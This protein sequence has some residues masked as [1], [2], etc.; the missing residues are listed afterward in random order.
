MAET[1]RSASGGR[2]E[3]GNFKPPSA[4]GGSTEEGGSGNRLSRL[5]QQAGQPAIWQRAERLIAESTSKGPPA[6]SSALPLHARSEPNTATNLSFVYSY[7]RYGEA[8]SDGSYRPVACA[9]PAPFFSIREILMRASESS[10]AADMC[11][12][13]PNL[14]QGP[15]GPW[16]QCQPDRAWASWAGQASPPRLQRVGGCARFSRYARACCV[17]HA[18]FFYHFFVIITN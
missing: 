3:P 8:V 9:R 14:P 11:R 13:R 15:A 10:T 5:G 6:A 4:A 2:A 17:W 16:L 7:C 12:N 1:S 18:L